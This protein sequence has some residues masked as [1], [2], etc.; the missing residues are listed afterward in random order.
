MSMLPPCGAPPIKPA[1]GLAPIVPP[2]APLPPPCNNPDRSADISMPPPGRPCPPPMSPPM[3]N[4]G[5][6][7]S[8]ACQ[9]I[10]CPMPPSP[11]MPMLGGACMPRAGGAACAPNGNGVEVEGKL[12]GLAGPAAL[13]CAL[14][15]GHQF[16][17]VLDG[18]DA[19]LVE[20]VATDRGD[21]DRG[22]LQRRLAFGRGDLD[23]VQVLDLAGSG[24]TRRW[25]IG[26][27]PGCVGRAGGEYSGHGDVKR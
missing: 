11:P 23:R 5:C 4:P 10:P 3:P 26:L 7:A 14:K 18:H 8:R 24:S 16:G 12:D 9:G 6:I 27:L 1:N 15:S 20:R 19:L 22:V 13:R 21:R 25:L 2:W 17:E